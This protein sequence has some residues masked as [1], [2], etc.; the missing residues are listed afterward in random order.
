MLA[1]I[2]GEQRIQRHGFENVP[3]VEIEDITFQEWLE[4]NKK[5]IETKLNFSLDIAL[6]CGIV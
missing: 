6:Q 5:E 4:K 3:V 1:R 2:A